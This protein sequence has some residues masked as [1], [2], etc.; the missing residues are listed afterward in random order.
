VA[1]HLDHTRT[2]EDLADAY[3]DRWSEAEVA[4]RSAILCG[5]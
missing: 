2:T 4:D 5:V 3:C 1:S